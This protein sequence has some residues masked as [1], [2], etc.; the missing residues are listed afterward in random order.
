[1][2]VTVEVDIERF[3]LAAEDASL[4]L[5]AFRSRSRALNSFSSVRVA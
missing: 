3:L 4:L 1:M 2:Y 5:T